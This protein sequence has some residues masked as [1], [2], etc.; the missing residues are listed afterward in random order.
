MAHSELVSYIHY[1][2]SCASYMHKKA[3]QVE[4]DLQVHL[5]ILLHPAKAVEP[6]LSS[7]NHAFSKTDFS[8]GKSAHCKDFCFYTTFI[9][10]KEQPP[11]QKQP[12]NKTEKPGGGA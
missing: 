3:L 1:F 8:C 5:L 11:Q 7:S 4:Q 12:Q 2:P 6:Q 10:K 9:L